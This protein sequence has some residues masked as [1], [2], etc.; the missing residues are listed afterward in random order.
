MGRGQREKEREHPSRH[1][2]ERRARCRVQSHDPEIILPEP[3]PR[4]TRLT[5]CATLGDIF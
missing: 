4:V 3:K 5:H 2:T 1:P